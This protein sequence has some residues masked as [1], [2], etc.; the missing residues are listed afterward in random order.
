MKND[1]FTPIPKKEARIQQDIFRWFWNEHCRPA[2]SPRECIFHVA[3]EGQ[4]R[5]VSIGVLAGVSDLV[6]TWGG[7]TYYCEVKDVKGTQL[8][9]Q[10]KFQEHIESTGHYYFLVRSLEDFK[11]ELDGIITKSKSNK[12][13]DGERFSK[14]HFVDPVI[15]HGGNV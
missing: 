10:V 1:N 14:I 3:N 2:C 11:K 13:S 7:N 12:C 6:F 8:P 9:S 15:F 4:H 5:L